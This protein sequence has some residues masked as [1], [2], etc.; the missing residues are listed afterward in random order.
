MLRVVKK[1]CM[2]IHSGSFKVIQNYIDESGV[3]T[4]YQLS[5]VGLNMGL[6]CTVTDLL[7][8]E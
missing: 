8:V 1:I 5:I 7:S 4:S 6:S 2:Q 3:H